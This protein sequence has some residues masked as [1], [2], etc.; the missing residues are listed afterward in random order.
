M[1]KLVGSGKSTTITSKVSACCSHWKASVLTMC[2]LGLC[3][4]PPFSRASV[5]VGREA[6]RHGRVRL[7]QGDRF[8]RGCRR[9]AHRHAVAAAGTATALGAPCAAWRG[10][11]G[12][13]GSGTRRDSAELQVAVEEQPVPALPCVTTMRW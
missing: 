13:R 1:E 5:R 10:A 11:L 3:S 12:P 6:W 9:S 8:N 7:H 4:A 2:G